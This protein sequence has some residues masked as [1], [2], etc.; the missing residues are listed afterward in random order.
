MNLMYKEYHETNH[1]D[2]GKTYYSENLGAIVRSYNCMNDIT[3][4]CIQT[5]A[6]FLNADPSQ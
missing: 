1:A 3:L 5:M 4:K 2:E 6:I